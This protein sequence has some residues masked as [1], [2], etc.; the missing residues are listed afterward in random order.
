MT[1]NGVASSDTRFAP[2]QTTFKGLRVGQAL[3]TD[4]VILDGK[5]IV[6]AGTRVTPEL[7][8]RL[9]NTASVSVLREPIVAG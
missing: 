6:E 8:T 9:R 2:Q 5:K 3:R 1:I 7:I 4:V